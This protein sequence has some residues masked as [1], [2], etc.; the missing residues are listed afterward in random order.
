MS[1]ELAN[2]KKK[3]NKPLP[4]EPKP[5]HSKKDTKHWCKGKVG[6]EHKLEWIDAPNQHYSEWM[7]QHD[8]ER[9]K[10]RTCTVCGKQFEYC[11][12]S[13]WSGKQ[14]CICGLHKKVAISG[15]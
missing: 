6:R 10:I 9:Y 11:W 1:E 4:E 3:K 14:D 7:R 8:I 13:T 5:S 12:N 15:S 2:F